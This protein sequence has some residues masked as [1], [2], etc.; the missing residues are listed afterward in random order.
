MKFYRLII[1]SIVIS[2]CLFCSGCRL[3]DK[4]EEP[5][6]DWP[7]A[8]LLQIEGKVIDYT[9]NLPIIGASVKL[10]RFAVDESNLKTSTIT[11][12]NGNYYLEWQTVHCDEYLKLRAS[13]PEQY[14]PFDYG[15]GLDYLFYDC[16]VRCTNEL[17]VINL[18]LRPT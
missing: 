2:S 16:C 8:I 12:S 13:K 15:Y 10:Y 4:Q 1:Y 11:D 18:Y 14:M 6:E 17:Q 9:T 7:N 5:K 3:S